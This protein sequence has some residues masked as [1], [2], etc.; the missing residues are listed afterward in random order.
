MY[1]KTISYLSPELAFLASLKVKSLI[2]EF[3]GLSDNHYHIFMPHVYQKLC[4]VVGSLTG[5]S[6]NSKGK[7]SDI[8]FMSPA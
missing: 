2:L 8:A 6:V 3:R 4:V 5:G 1:L 7:H